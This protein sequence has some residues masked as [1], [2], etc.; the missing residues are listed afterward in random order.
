MRSKR[1]SS[2]AIKRLLL[3]LLSICLCAGYALAGQTVGTVTHLSGP[4][5]AKKSD[6]STK[7]LTR[8]SA[9][10]EGDTLVTEKRTYARIK[11]L[12][13]SDVTL[14]PNTLFKVER[15]AYDEK[16]PKNDSAVMSLVKG[17]LRSVTGK[18]GKRGNQDAYE[19]KTP[20]ATIG[21]RG[22]VYGATFCQGS[23]CG[24][25]PKG[26]YVDVADGKI[27]VSNKGGAQLVTAGQFGFVPSPTALPVILPKNPGASFTPPPAMAGPAPGQQKAGQAGSTPAKAVDCE[28]R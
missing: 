16:A 20:T 2:S 17:G 1:T 5:L 26:L 21:I 6:G 18:V 11:F 23:E 3:A 4:L 10:E 7:V 12:D 15:F 24:A 13:A 9:V 19:M 27:V 22:T 14:K 8:N 28:V 25:L